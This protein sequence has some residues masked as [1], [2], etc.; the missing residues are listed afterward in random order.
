VSQTGAWQKW[1]RYFL[2]AVANQSRDAIRR[3]DRLLDLGKA[4]HGQV[5]QARWSA[6]LVQLIDELLTSPAIANAGVCRRLK[7]TPRSAQL[8]IDK[9]V[10]RGILREA[11]GRQR[12]RI[13]VGTESVD[14]IE[15]QDP[16]LE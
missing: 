15:R 1:I 7:I 12:N 14:I 4:Y 8:N 2:R 3:I 5:Q 16:P 9:L 13:Y 6:L 10:E 11:T